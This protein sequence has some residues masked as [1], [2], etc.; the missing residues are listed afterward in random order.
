MTMVPTRIQAAA[1][2]GISERQLGN[3]AN[4]F[5]FPAGGHTDEGWNLDLIR[6][7]IHVMGRKGSKQR[8]ERK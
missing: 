7:V 2:L 5:W 1:A 6:A 3:W 4:E 8:E